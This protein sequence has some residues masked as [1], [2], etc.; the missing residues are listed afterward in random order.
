MAVNIFKNINR[1]LTIAGE[2]IYTVPLAYSGIILS[3]QISNITGSTQSFSMYVVNLDTS[4]VSLVTDFDVPGYDSASALVGK[5]V[6]EPGQGLFVSASDD[7]SLKLVVS[8][9]ESQN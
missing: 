1:N 6:L 8:L 3:A 4:T 5:L 7:T 2:T 9:L